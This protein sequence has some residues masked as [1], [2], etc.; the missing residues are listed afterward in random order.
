[1]RTRVALL[2]AAVTVAGFA[3]VP[4]LG[5]QAAS[6]AQVG[7]FSAPFEDMR[8]EE[9]SG[10]C[11][12]DVDGRKL[13]KPA[14]ASVVLL[15]NGKLLYWDA[16][17]GTENIKLSL[18]AEF[19]SLAR[20]DRTRVLDLSG[21][22]P[23]F[24]TPTPADGG[25]NPN[26]NTAQTLPVLPNSA[27]ET[28]VND[29]DLFCSDQV[30]LSDGR[31]LAV[32]GTDY[33][34]EPNVPGTQ[35]GVAEL[36]G[37]KNGRI[38][39]PATNQWTQTGSMQNGRWYPS[40]VTL[41]DGKVLVASG[42][43]KLVKPVYP[44]QPL[45]SGTNVKQLEVYDPATGAWST[46]PDTANRS[47]P[48]FPRLHLLPNGHIYYDVAGQSFNPFGQS[49]D[50]SLWNLA[51]TFDP[52]TNTWHDLGI[53][54][55]GGLPPIPDVPGVTN[56]QALGLP[57][58]GLPTTSGLDPLGFGFRGSTFS[59]MLPLTPDASGN[60]SAASFLS[61]GG[62]L[63]AV[64]PSPGTYLASNLS[65]VNTVYMNPTTGAESL[66]SAPTGNLKN[67]RWYSTGVLLP[68]GDV[69]AF[70]GA[71]VDEVDTPSVGQP[72]Q[73]AEL[74]DHETSTWKPM[75]SGNHPRT[76]HN[77]A[78]LLPD[79]RVLVGGHAPI[80]TLYLSNKQIPVVGESNPDRDPS[81]EIYEPPYLFNG[82]RPSIG[83]VPSTVGY[84]TTMVI[85]TKDAS[86]IENVVMMRNTA[87]THLVDGDQ[88]SVVLPIVARNQ[89]SVTVATPPRPEVAPRGP[90]LVFANKRVNGKLVP[91]VGRQVSVAGVAPPAAAIVTPTSSSPL[92]L[93]T[94]P[95]LPTVPTTVPAVLDPL[96]RLLG[97]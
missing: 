53:P 69:M 88:R 64:A 36:E 62:T 51:S 91:S 30:Q 24:T 93:P 9:G 47:L 3:V 78:I 75:A 29:G 43:T 58:D 16:L 14:G 4:S 86:T 59:I 63:S 32:G 46:L 26:G 70:S 28:A 57:V 68:T 54:G 20:N 87:I 61:A 1:M 72:V 18:I 38:F 12:V 7:R 25:A 42:V 79:G 50:E 40:L 11:L 65:R 41:P 55:V 5:A 45:S 48:L 34:S 37:L 96:N 77:T 27:G 6:P 39:N 97:R 19:G 95:K 21:S 83:Q 94:L 17:E 85:P 66:S 90:Y 22:S 67:A 56:S 84:G 33:Y 23:V 44:D 10:K 92:P 8:P 81:F 13:C 82:T 89:G 73:Q 71:N 31:I 60:Y 52:A 76:Y 15:S 80:S 2:A 74:F 49:Y 35:F